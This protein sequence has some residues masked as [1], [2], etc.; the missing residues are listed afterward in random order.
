MNKTVAAIIV[1]ENE[2]LLEKRAIEPFKGLWVLPGG[3]ANKDEDVEKA[4]I[5]EVH[6]ETGLEFFNINFVKQFPE[7]F[8]EIKWQGIVYVFVGD[9]KG[10]LK[11]DKESSELRFIHLE[12]IDQ[13]EM[14]FDHKK[15][16]KEVLL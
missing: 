5:R 12:E 14:G 16:I 15:I 11:M 10:D 1:K 8:P 4:V 13:L 9:A 2:I 7:Q 3:H 6:E